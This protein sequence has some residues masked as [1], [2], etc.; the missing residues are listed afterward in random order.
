MSMEE[1]L[2]CA[3]TSSIRHRSITFLTDSTVSPARVLA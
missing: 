2:A 1:V 3:V